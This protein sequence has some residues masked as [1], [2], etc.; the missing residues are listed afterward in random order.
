MTGIEFK[1]VSKRCGDGAVGDRDVTPLSPAEP[2]CATSR[3]ETLVV[4]GRV[5]HYETTHKSTEPR[6]YRIESAKYEH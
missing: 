1:N 5:N 2:R 6:E 4:Q 3:A